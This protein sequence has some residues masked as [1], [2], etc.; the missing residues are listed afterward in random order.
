[1]TSH[2]DLEQIPKNSGNSTPTHHNNHNNRNIEPTE[3]DPP[4]KDLGMD[5][6]AAE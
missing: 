6:T 5:L 3:P 4:P 2:Q 1:M